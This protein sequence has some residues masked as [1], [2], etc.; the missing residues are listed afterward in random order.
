MPMHRPAIL[1]CAALLSLGWS[2]L[3]GNQA[4]AQP[5]ATGV[6]PRP[7]CT[8]TAAPA[9]SATPPSG[10]GN[11]G[12]SPGGMG[13]TAWSGGTGGSYI[14]TAPAGPRPGSANAQ[15]AT[16]SGLDPTRPGP[17]NPSAC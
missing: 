14:G 11:S 6:D 5:A 2:V 9:P 15:P 16:A 8:A 17:A 4:A 13:S 1:A 3:A 7:P 12:T 10:G